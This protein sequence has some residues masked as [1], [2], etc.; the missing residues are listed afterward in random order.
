MILVVVMAVVMRMV[1]V[2]VKPMVTVVIL[3][4]VLSMVVMVVLIGQSQLLS[5]QKRVLPEPKCP[6]LFNFFTSQCQ[7]QLMAGISSISLHKF[8]VILHSP[9][10][11]HEILNLPL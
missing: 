10:L 1:E 5:I 11:T 2:E 6:N 9:S 7:W 3:E 4:I 8:L